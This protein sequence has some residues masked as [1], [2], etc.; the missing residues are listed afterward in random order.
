MIAESHV[1]RHSWQSLVSLTSSLKTPTETEKT[2][3]G[4]SNPEKDDLTWRERQD[5]TLGRN[6]ASTI[7]S[8]F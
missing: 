5:L 1:G 8:E 2:V 4:D 3:A 6:R 7:S